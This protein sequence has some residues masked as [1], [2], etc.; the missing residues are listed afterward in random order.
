[1]SSLVFPRSG[2]GCSAGVGLLHRSDQTEV[3]VSGFTLDVRTGRKSE[4][5]KGQTEGGE[6]LTGRAI[7][8]IKDLFTCY[9]NTS[10]MTSDDFISNVYEEPVT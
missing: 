5:V 6:S 7:N 2:R 4:T 3:S 9:R 10:H 1:M 8:F